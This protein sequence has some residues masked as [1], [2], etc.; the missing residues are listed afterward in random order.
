MNTLRYL[1]LGLIALPSALQCQPA[2]IPFP[3]SYMA[4][5]DEFVV[6]NSVV[7]LYGDLA[8]AHADY[9]KAWYQTNIG[10]TVVSKPIEEGAPAGGKF[11]LLN[12]GPHVD[13]EEVRKAIPQAPNLKLDAAMLRSSNEDYTMGITSVSMVLNGNGP[14]GLFYAIQTLIQLSQFSY[15]GNGKTLSVACAQIQDRPAFSHRGMLL[16][17]CRHF[18]PVELVMQYIDLL[19]FYKMN[20]LHWHLTDDQGWR[21]QIDAY[22]E[23]TEVGAWRTEKDGSRYGGYYSKEDI[24]KIIAYA[25]SRYVTVVPEIEMP[26]HS[27]AA[28][29]AYPWLSCTGHQIEVENEWGV[30]KDIYCAGN[31]S[32]YVFIENVLKEVCA[33]FPSRLIH[34]GGDEAPHTRWEACPKCKQCMKSNTLNTP[35]ELQAH[36]MERVGKILAKFDKTMIGWDE[37]MDGE[38]PDDACVQVWRSAN[39]GIANSGHRIVMSPTSHCYFDYPL[40]NIDMEKVYQFDPLNGVADDKAHL[41]MGGECNLW[42]EHIWPET[43][44]QKVFPRALAM[45]EVLWTY[46]VNRNYA[47]FTQ[48]VQAHYPLL[49]RMEVEY[50]YPTTPAKLKSQTL[51]EGMRISVQESIEGIHVSCQS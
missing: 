13:V 21:I 4:S 37:I 46:P 18:M 48:R 51:S 36:F 29:A 14:E 45:A 49:R 23:L 32:T 17:C 20:T 8:A 25:A 31:D 28:I 19:A 10:L 7:I 22:P 6:D 39:G 1:L 47:A 50:G 35:L 3:T 26:G 16:D 30:F 33:L 38:I 11:I 24:R 27:T 44:D 9:L 42:S 43:L 40:S 5:K 41:V 15:S 2:L 12:C 34:I